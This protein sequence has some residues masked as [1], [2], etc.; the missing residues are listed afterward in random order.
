MIFVKSS[1][2]ISNLQKKYKIMKRKEKERKF[3]NIETTRTLLLGRFTLKRLQIQNRTTF[4]WEGNW[5]GGNTYPSD[6]VLFYLTLTPL[7]H[8]IYVLL[9]AQPSINPIWSP[10]LSSPPIK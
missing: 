10:H 3:K 6:S 8:S 4:N 2:I 9:P 1:W 7:S 5:K